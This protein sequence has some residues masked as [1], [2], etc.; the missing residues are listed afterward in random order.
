MKARFLAVW[1]YVYP[2]KMNNIHLDDYTLDDQ[3]WMFGFARTASK[4]LWISI[5][6]MCLGLFAYYTQ[7]KT[8]EP[9]MWASVVMGLSFFCGNF[10][11]TIRYY[12]FRTLPLPKDTKKGTHS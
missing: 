12:H 8:L 6:V 5:A 4:I 2:Y 9:Y 7:T 3:Q 10:Y 1:K 11:F